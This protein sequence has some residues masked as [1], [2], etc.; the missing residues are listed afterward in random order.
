MSVQL[1]FC[2]VLLPGFVQNSVQH[3]FVVPSSVFCVRFVSNMWC[4]HI[5]VWTQLQLERNPI[6][7]YRL[8]QKTI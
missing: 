5:V 6:L 3:S 7:L 1:L 8:D 4:I 2:G